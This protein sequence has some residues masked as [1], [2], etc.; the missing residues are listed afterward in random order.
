MF[1]KEITTMPLDQ[2]AA[3]LVAL[4]AMEPTKD[5]TTLITRLKDRQRFLEAEYECAKLAHRLILRGNGML[6]IGEAK[7]FYEVC[8]RYGFVF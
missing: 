2:I 3:N 4:E 7:Q 6:P 5:V 1:L 8:D